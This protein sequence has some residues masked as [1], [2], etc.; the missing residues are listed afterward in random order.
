MGFLRSS[1]KYK[2][3][4]IFGL[5]ALLVAIGVSFGYLAVNQSVSDFRALSNYELVH[6]RAVSTMVTDFKK[7][8]Q[9]WKNVLLRGANP[10][11]LEK[12]WGKFQKQEAGIQQEGA[13]LV[14]HMAPGTARDK[15]EAFLAAHKEM[16]SAYRSGYQAFVASGF[17]PTAGDRAV[18]G[19]DRA[20]TKLLE[21]AA[22]LIADGA[23]AATESALDDASFATDASLVAA[24]VALLVSVLAC[25][26]MLKRIVL[27]PI[28][29]VVS[30]LDN[31][32]NGDFKT[33]INLQSDDE[34]GQL[35]DS[36][37]HLRDD[38][39]DLIRSMVAIAQ[40]LD[41]AG[42]SLAA[43]STQ[44]RAQLNDQRQGT[45]QVATASEQLAATAEEVA[46][47]TTRAAASAN[48]AG[49][50]S[51]TGRQIVAEA[52]DVMRQLESNVGDVNKVLLDLETHS[53]A[54]GNV[55][56]VIRGIA[57][58][59][60]LLALN[61]AIEAA[62]AGDQGR[63]FA[64]VADEVRSLAQRTQESTQEI[65]TTIEQLQA[66]SKA[67]VQAMDQ[68]RSRV[69]EGVE[70]TR[71]VEDSL[72]EIDTSVSTIVDM[73]TQI[74]AAAEEQGVVARDVSRNVT[75]IDQ[76]G[77]DLVD[78]ADSLAG[79]SQEIARMSAQLVA[80]AQRFKV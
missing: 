53:V 26:V 76:S 63:G 75:A 17:D 34:I 77:G 58:Q 5:G 25:V 10:E 66:G 30:V 13:E 49:S 72:R 43:L 33:D 19:I 64:V 37:R 65:E 35:A 18:K 42:T 1:L 28:A 23:G 7:Q 51:S 52:I 22:G 71:Q 67:A 32:A 21:E 79:N 70:R 57:E 48:A 40:Q 14:Q 6:E 24:L 11:Q 50:A 12:Y 69:E 36:A 20:P 47:G 29:E 74:A 56:S 73:N 41:T 38:L 4:A 31:L 61:A 55:L 16:G 2:F 8:V 45:A 59:T 68:G 39:G 44:N 27:R 54:I 9:E 62:R 15:V 46:S 80:A 60:N 3:L 78:A